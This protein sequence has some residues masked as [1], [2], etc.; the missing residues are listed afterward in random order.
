[1]RSENKG[2]KPIK[3]SLQYNFSRDIV[4]IDINGLLG[5]DTY[6]AIE[7]ALDNLFQ[8]KQYRL[9][10]NMTEVDYIASPVLW[11]FIWAV[12][13]AQ[14]NNGNLVIYNP[15]KQVKDSFESLQTSAVL[16]VITA[17]MR[18]A[19]NTFGEK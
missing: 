14:D 8:E 6:E 19:F 9:I 16:P 17:S 1:M 11:L 13:N 10:V 2:K 18:T 12:K 4:F 15:N 7:K 3:I 5:N